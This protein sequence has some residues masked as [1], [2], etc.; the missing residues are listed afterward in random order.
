MTVEAA[1]FDL[2]SDE[3]KKDPYPTYDG[4][5]RDRPVHRAEYPGGLE[6]W[7]V[8]KYDDVHT[9]LND[10]RFSMSSDNSASPFFR[11]EE[12]DPEQAGLDRNL[13]NLDP[14]AHGPLRKLVTREFTA[15]RVAALRPQMERHVEELVDGFAGTGSADLIRQFAMP[16]PTG[17]A[18][19]LLGVP[20]ADWD[21]FRVLSN[22]LVTPEYDM[23][24]DDFDILKRKIRAYVVRLIDSKRAEPADDLVSWLAKGCYDEGEISPDD[25]VGT[26]FT[27]LV[28]SHETTTNFV[29]NAALALIN[30]PD[31]LATLRR[32]P[33]LIGNAVEELLRYDGPFEVSSLRF[34]LAD[35]E[36]GGTVIPKGATVVG[37]IA[38]ANRDPARFPAPNQLDLSRADVAHLS[39]GV[40]THFCPG[41]RLALLEAEIALSVLV[42]R[43]SDLRLADDRPLRWRA[44]LFFRGLHELP[45]TFTAT[46]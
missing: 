40:G 23:G 37:V 35:V 25:L 17:V 43:L 22:T 36:L 15:A 21:E 12:K 7:L 19:E 4:L 28:G 10:P 11:E 6:I 32:R 1:T 38:A 14:P 44:G 42:R 41:R 3:F 26:V 16:L 2:Y 24:P 9:V 13:L 34:T 20:P 45:V 5:R 29:G 31:Q 18:G 30:H 8:T 27:L 33:E 46:A 39:F